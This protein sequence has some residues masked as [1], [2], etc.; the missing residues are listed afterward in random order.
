MSAMIE[1]LK[2]AKLISPKKAEWGERQAKQREQ[3][4]QKLIKSKVDPEEAKRMARLVNDAEVKRREGKKF[5]DRRAKKKA[6]K[7]QSK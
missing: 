7:G 2:N 6:S 1:A 5:A 3:I 4:A